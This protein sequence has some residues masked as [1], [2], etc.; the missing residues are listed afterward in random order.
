M[1]T[2]IYAR[3][4][5]DR[6][7]TFAGKTEVIRQ[8]FACHKTLPFEGRRKQWEGV[9]FIADDKAKI[10]GNYASFDVIQ[11]RDRPQRAGMSMIHLLAVP[12]ERITNALDL[13]PENVDI[14]DHM[15][16]LFKKL[17]SEPEKRRAIIEHQLL[18]IENRGKQEDCNR[19][20]TDLARKHFRELEDDAY[21]L[22][23]E[24]FYF[25]L[26]LAPDASANDL[27]LHIIAAPAKFRKYSTSKHDEKTKDAIEV[28]DFILRRAQNL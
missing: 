20:D 24:D 26:H 23:A 11:Y 25:G 3:Q 17:W 15:I 16:Q 21:H 6:E 4:L 2:A 22:Q 18:T 12:E 10:V 14:I 7:G 28:R 19:A 27:H 1:G 8:Q 5:P 13:T 9:T